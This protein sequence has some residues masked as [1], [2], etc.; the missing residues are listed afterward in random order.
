LSRPATVPRR[1]DTVLV[2]TAEFNARGEAYK[3]IDPAAREDRVEF[4]HA[5]RQVKT[6]QN[7]VNGN[8]TDGTPDQDVTVETAYN[9]DGRV[10]KITAKQQNSANDQVTTYTY[11]VTTG[12][13]STLNSNDLLLKVEYPDSSAW[14]DN[15]SYTYKRSGQVIRMTDQH[16]YDPQLR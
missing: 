11:G 9:V 13:G 4:D 14:D 3:T 16:G 8:P 2:A 6:I 10:R 5:G 1:S 12:G 15:V 7:Y